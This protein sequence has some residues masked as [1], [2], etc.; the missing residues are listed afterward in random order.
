MKKICVFAL[1]LALVLPLAPAL[2]PALSATALADQP[3]T[4][5][6]GY[7]WGMSKA[8]AIQLAE[9]EGLE[10]VN[11]KNP[12]YVFLKDVPVGQYQTTMA[13][14]FNEQMTLHV[15]SYIFPEPRAADRDTLLPQFHSLREALVGLYGAISTESKNEYALW[16]LPDADILLFLVET[17]DGQEFE[18]VSVLYS[19]T[20]EAQSSL[21]AATQPAAFSLRSGYFFGMSKA[22]ALKLAEEEG[23]GP[24]GSKGESVASFENVPV[25]GSA[26][27][28]MLSFDAQM[29]LEAITYD[30]P[31]VP[32]EDKVGQSLQFNTLMG[33]LAD[34]YGPPDSVL[35]NIHAQWDLPDVEISL[36]ESKDYDN[37]GLQCGIVS[38]H[39]KEAVQNAGY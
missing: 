38:Y 30:F 11:G 5:R 31:G 32:Q 14:A 16:K 2:S 39:R 34:V 6:N 10:V 9:E 20:E 37:E 15:I 26:V 28:M 24:N 36:L 4:L 19:Q 25:G 7:H 23:L 29:T 27:R 1:L 33:T 22:D 8:E 18:S 35:G 21:P 12:E 13:L 3:F 17:E